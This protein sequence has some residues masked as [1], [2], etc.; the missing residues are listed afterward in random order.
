MLDIFEDSCDSLDLDRIKDKIRAIWTKIIVAD[1]NNQY[2]TMKDDDENFVTLDQ[3]VE[4]NQLYFP[5]DN[6]PED[7]VSSIVQML[8]DMF[9]P[10]EELDSVKG[11]GKAPTY[12]GSQLKANNDGRKMESTSYEF[13]FTSTKTPGDSKSLVKSGTYKEPSGGRIASRKDSK[14]RRSYKPL[15]DKIVEELLSIEDRRRTGRREFMQRI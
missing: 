8:E 3:F 15:M 13:E 10:K 4:D 14:V 6:K 11:E 9:D 12:G 1:Y 7:E 5:G 2:G